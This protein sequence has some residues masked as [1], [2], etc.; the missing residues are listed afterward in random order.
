M[1][2]LGFR[3]VGCGWRHGDTTNR[4]QH[5]CGCVWLAF[6]VHSCTSHAFRSRNSKI[7]GIFGCRT[8]HLRYIR[9]FMVPAKAKEGKNAKNKF[10]SPKCQN[11][12]MPKCVG[13]RPHCGPSASLRPPPKQTKQGVWGRHAPTVARVLRCPPHNHTEQGVCTPHCRPSVS[14]YS[15]PKQTK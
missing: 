13:A 10:S 8:P 5:V 9:L 7:I 14:L 6:G 11:T 2:K 4:L 12:K 1:R 15:P 3:N